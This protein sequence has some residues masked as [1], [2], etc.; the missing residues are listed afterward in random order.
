MAVAGARVASVDPVAFVR[1]TPPFDALPQA[2]FDEVAG[3]IDVAFHPAGSWLARAGGEPLRHLHVIRKG[4]VRLERDGR[5]V[6]V[7]EEGEVFGYTSLLSREAT[8]DVRVEDDLVACRL[9]D[10]EFQRLRADARFA[11]HFAA[12]LAA[13]LRACLECAPAPVARLDLSQPVDGLLRRAAVWVAAG[14]TVGDAARTM[15]AERVSSVL[16]RGEPPG[17]VTDRD[18]QDRVLAEGLGPDTPVARVLSRPLR[19]L[20]AATPL[21]EAWTALLDAGVHHLPLEREG[22]IAGVLTATDLLRSTAQGPVAL[23]RRLD[24]LS[25]RAELPAYRGWIAEMA[26]AL[27]AGRLDAAAIAGLVARLDDALVRKLLSWAEDELGP[28]PAPYAWLALGAEGRMEQAVPVDQDNTLVYA[29]EG[30]AARD[31]FQALA[32]RVNADLEAAGFPRSPYPGDARRQHG[33]LSE[34]AARLRECVDGPRP[35]EAPRLFDLR[36]V[37]GRLD[38]APLEAEVARAG[39][40]PLFLRFLAREALKLTPPGALALGL[41]SGTPLDLRRHGVAPVVHLA[42]C[43]ALEVGSRA[44]PTL[45][46]LADAARAG[47]MA[48]EACAAVSEAYRFLQS[49][50]LRG[51]LRALAAGEPPSDAVAPADLGPIERSRLKEAFHA[52]ERWQEKAAYHYQTDFV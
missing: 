33:T 9:P 6:Q 48:A 15:R 47:L 28:A 25:G 21:H 23:S 8:L 18:F 49:L 50:R 16:V 5:A 1:S 12:G 37:A 14:A 45:E 2:L 17:I 40:N 10:A 29:D 35:H 32:E 20:A 41:R 46:R 22:E 39:R 34:W 24:R 52:I 4:A 31:R 30:A 43:Y 36:R 38:P 51:H 19:T 42:R 27:L 44:R 7:L 11:G 13:R 3:A 26:S